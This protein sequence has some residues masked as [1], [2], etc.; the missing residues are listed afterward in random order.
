MVVHFMKKREIIQ[1][2]SV[3][4]FKQD[5]VDFQFSVDTQ[6]IRKGYLVMWMFGMDTDCIYFVRVVLTPT[7]LWAWVNV[8]RMVSIHCVLSSNQSEFLRFRLIGGLRQ[9]TL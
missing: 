3:E 9:P 6:A 4:R 8:F 5:F 1:F 7:P 2:K